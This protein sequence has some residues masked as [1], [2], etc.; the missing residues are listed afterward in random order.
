[1]TL[2]PP[3]ASDRRLHRVQF[4][5]EM[6]RRKSIPTFGLEAIALIFIASYCVHANWVSAATLELVRTVTAGTHAIPFF[7]SVLIFG[8]IVSIDR[9][10]LLTLL[11]RIAV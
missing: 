4:A 10:T 9:R 6:R 2:R 11:P 3:S 7:V 8:S 1:M 5:F